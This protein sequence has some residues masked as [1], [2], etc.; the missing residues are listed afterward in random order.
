MLAAWV[1]G[2]E[3]T[4]D[5]AGPPRRTGRAAHSQSGGDRLPQVLLEG[6][7]RFG[8]PDQA[9]KVSPRDAKATGG[10]GLVAVVLADGGNGE[11]DFVFVNLA[12]KGAG[13]LVIADVD[14]IFKPGGVV[15]VVVQGEVFA[16]TVWPGA[17]MMAR[18]MTFSNSRTLP[19][20]E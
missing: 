1:P 17:R 10:E 5:I 20:Q 16:R 13:R 19:G 3:A 12:L 18:C 6:L 9:M 4:V 2:A 7:I 15:F 14:H 8:K 11:L